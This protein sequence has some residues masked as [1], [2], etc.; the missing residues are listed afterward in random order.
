M[1]SVIAQALLAPIATLGGVTRRFI[2]V[3]G[4]PGNGKSTDADARCAALI[5]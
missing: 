3:M 4:P 5:A 1:T 2:A